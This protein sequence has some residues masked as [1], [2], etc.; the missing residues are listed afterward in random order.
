MTDFEGKTF[1]FMGEVGKFYDV[2]SEK[3]HQVR[4]IVLLFCQT[5]VV[6]CAASLGAEHV[7]KKANMPIE[8]IHS[9]ADDD[10]AEAGPDVGPQWHLHGWDWLPIPGPQSCCGIRHR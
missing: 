8:E 6:P 5:A 4:P 2:I 9:L 3:D 1:E 10:E 7:V